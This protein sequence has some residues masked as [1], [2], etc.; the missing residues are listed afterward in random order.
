MSITKNRAGWRGLLGC[1]AV[2]ALLAGTRC[3]AALDRNTAQCHTNDDCAARFPGR[4]HP[5]CKDTVCIPSPYEPQNCFLATPSQPPQTEEDFLNQCTTTYIGLGVDPNSIGG[6]AQECLSFDCQRAGSC[7]DG[8]VDAE[9]PLMPPPDAGTMAAPGPAPGQGPD[10]GA[11][12]PTVSCA[13]AVAGQ[14]LYMTG[15]SNFPPLL[16]KLTP[17]IQSLGLT[18]IFKTTDSCTGATSMNRDPTRPGGYVAAHTIKDPDAGTTGVYAQYYDDK[19][20]GHPCTLAPSGNDVDVGESE[21]SVDTCKA[22]FDD[23]VVR[24]FSGPILPMLFVVPKL[25]MERSISAEAARLIFG[26]GGMLP[27]GLLGPN[28]QPSI[29]PWSNPNLYFIRGAGTATARLIGLAIDA[30]V[31]PGFWGID[32]GQADK[33]ASNLALVGDL[34]QA[35]GAIGILGED[36]FDQNRDK[37]KV[38]A[39]KA[40][41]QV[42][43]YNPDT[44]SNL[45]TDPKDRINVRDGHYPIWGTL[46]FFAALQGGSLLSAA[47]NVLLG[48]LTDNGMLPQALLDA[49]IAAGWVPDCAMKVQ[50]EKDLG[51]VTSYIAPHP[52]GCYFDAKVNGGLVPTGSTCVACV[53]NTGCPAAGT[54]CSY[55]Y[56]EVFPP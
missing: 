45:P 21:I 48:S 23:S 7:T 20:I 56:C 55:G 34:S 27:S 18:P 1:F 17:F 9:P 31:P 30:P 22:S 35:Q 53:G 13:T 5:L 43:A 49:Y 14:A 8:G 32:Q 2:A 51:P 24:Q 29:S 33:L 28:G 54:G 41:N 16:Q 50:R 12:K 40:R 37:L 42:C 38:L 10:A 36:Y 39:F 19:G 4:A 26:N 46:R 47:A 6:A 52:C 44:N 11:G 3:T 15:S 25:S